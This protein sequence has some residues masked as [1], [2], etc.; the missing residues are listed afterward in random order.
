M[1]NKKTKKTS[2]AADDDPLDHEIDFSKS[3]PNP[4]FVAVHGPAYVRVIDKD[5]AAL[6]P[7]DAS[8]NAALRTIAETAAR[9]RQKIGA[10]TA[11]PKPKKRVRA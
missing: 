4:W 7:D 10:G 5:L 6:F 9:I 11:T 3:I 8:M 1:K 2:E